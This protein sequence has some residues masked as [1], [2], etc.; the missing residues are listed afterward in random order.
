MEIPPGTI[1]NVVRA[2]VPWTPDVITHQGLVLMRDGERA[3]FVRHASPVWKRVVDEPLDHFVKRY[4][5]PSK[6]QPWKV[7]GLNLLRITDPKNTK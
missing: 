3:R 1:V 7:I 5:H 2:D 4:E 6:P